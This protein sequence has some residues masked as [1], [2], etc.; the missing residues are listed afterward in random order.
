MKTFFGIPASAGIAIGRAFVQETEGF[1]IPQHFIDESSL[2]TEVGR[3]HAAVGHAKEEI[4]TNRDS[5]KQT[6]GQSFADIFAAQLAVLFDPK[7]LEEIEGL[8]RLQRF[9]A[10]HAVTVVMGKHINI[11]RQIKNSYIAEKVND[12]HDIE[13]RLLRHLLGTKKETYSNLTSP[14]VLM[15]RNL[16]PGET[17][18]LDKRFVQAIVT[19]TGGQGGHTAIL[20]AALEIP[21]VVG[22]AGFQNDTHGGDI[23]IVDGNS[24][25][26]IIRPDDDTQEKYR[27]ISDADSSRIEILDSMRDL[28]AVT[29]DGVKITVQAN[30]EFPYEAANALK[31]GADG[32]GLFRTE[33]LYLTQAADPTE[34][35]HFNSYKQVVDVMQGHPVVIRTFDFGDD[36]TMDRYYP[37]PERNPALGLR[38]IRLALKR[39]DLFRCQLRAILRVSAFGDVRIMFPLVSTVKEFRQAKRTALQETMDELRENGIPF[40]ENLPVGMMVEVPSAVIMLDKFAEDA[41][42]FSVGTNDLIQYTMAVDR[43][44]SNVNHLF[45]AEDP[46]VLRLL[47]RIVVV[48]KRRDIPV[49]LCGQMGSNPQNVVLLLGLG[50][51]CISCAPSSINRVKQICRYVTVPE[52][53]E[54]AHR[55]VRMSNAQDIADFIRN[56]LRKIA[57]E[58]YGSDL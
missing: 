22:A 36:K 21:C 43:G 6:L 40:N 38:G 16:T 48:S 28:A 31:R 27:L 54:M 5:T 49:S 1:R 12:I 53:E 19:E 20:A 41:D 45:C 35:E 57:P 23:V 25:A 58:V 2:E 51:R 50:L 26:V 42:F 46:A 56:K 17:A 34:E 9:S 18:S 44:N 32:I 14:V 30:I 3:F 7:L 15:A 47:R 33:F 10:E 8:I 11:F 39:W 13:K 55:A 52:C 24:G 37:I 29:K 4:E